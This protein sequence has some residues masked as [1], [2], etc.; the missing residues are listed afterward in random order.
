MDSK[1][2][3]VSYM[4]TKNLRLA[5]FA[6]RVAKIFFLQAK[7]R[8]FDY[9]YLRGK[10]HHLS[11]LYLKVTPLCNLRCVMCG[12]YGVKGVLKG[13]QVIEESKQILSL[14]AYKNLI[15]QLRFHRPV[16]YIWGGEPFLYP[17]LM[18]LAQY[19]VKKKMPLALNTNGTFLEKHAE[20]IV[21]DKWGAIYVSLDGFEDTNDSI[22]GKGSYR[23][24]MDGI[25]A[26]DREKKRQKSLF[27]NLGLV[28]V[29]SNQNYLYL[30]ELVKAGQDYGLSWHIINLGT[31]TSNQVVEENRKFYR[32]KTQR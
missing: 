13:K 3:V 31:Y 25:R 1:F 23:K 32:E 28:T 22:R 30:D 21:R 16:I 18:D 9:R 15:D 2:S 17:H 20:R 10:A 5:G 11:L 12:Q 26:I 14:D 24:V 8:N 27:P 7:T 19:I 6:M 29:V 4:L